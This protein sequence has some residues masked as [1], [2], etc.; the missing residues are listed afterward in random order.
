MLPHSRTGIR[1]CTTTP[2]LMMWP[3]ARPISPSWRARG[4]ML[5]IGASSPMLV[6]FPPHLAKPAQIFST[7]VTMLAEH[8]GGSSKQLAGLQPVQ[9]S[10]CAGF[11]ALVMYSCSHIPAAVRH[12]IPLLLFI[13][14]GPTHVLRLQ[15][16][17]LSLTRWRAPLVSISCMMKLSCR[18]DLA[19]ASA[20]CLVLQVEPGHTQA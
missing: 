13:P 6:Q 12:T 3:S 5:P 9:G 19:T 4:T 14:L 1:S 2:L 15:D 20:A 18:M 17:H 11:A 16:R 8:V 7:L 10:D